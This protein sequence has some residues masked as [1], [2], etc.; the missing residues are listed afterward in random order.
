M[1]RRVA[2]MFTASNGVEVVER[3]GDIYT[4]VSGV[5][6]SHGVRGTALIEYALRGN[7]AEGSTPVH[8][9]PE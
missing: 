1:D 9:V 8:D 4:F 6:F 3:N 5:R 7:C 2:V